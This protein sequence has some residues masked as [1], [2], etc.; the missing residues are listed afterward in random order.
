[1]KK[2]YFLL[3]FL[4]FC[5]K[6]SFAQIVGGNVFLQGHWLEVGIDNMGA[7]GTCTSP[8]G[9]HAHGTASTFPSVCF[10]AGDKL[11]ACYDWGHDGWGIGTPCEMGDYTIP[12]Y[13]Q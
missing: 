7:F 4:F 1:M 6:V 2:L 3:V 12:G 13:P 10:S 9:Y 11:D 8:P 5:G